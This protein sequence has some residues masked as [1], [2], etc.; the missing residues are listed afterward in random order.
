MSRRASLAAIAAGVAFAVVFCR[1]QRR[2]DHPLIDLDLF[3]NRAFSTALAIGLGGGVVMA[4]TFLLLSMYLQLVE[5]LSP[6]RAGLCLVPLNVAMAVASMP[7]PQLVR[8]YRVA[9]VM[10]AGLTIAA[11]GLLLVT[12]AGGEGG[13]PWLLTGFLLACVGIAWPS[14]LGTNLV[15]GSVPSRRPGPRRRCP[16]PAV[17]WASPLAWR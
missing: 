6:L 1:R 9:Y 17:S 11:C 2:L 3:R 12:Q 10:A 8:R 4:G 13:L 15:V 5:G 7:A 14:A 16:R